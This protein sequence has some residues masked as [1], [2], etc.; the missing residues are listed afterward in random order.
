LLGFAINRSVSIGVCAGTGFVGRQHFMR[1][2]SVFDH[3]RLIAVAP[4]GMPGAGGTIFD[5]RNLE[6][7]L[8]KLA[9]QTDS[10]RP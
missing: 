3:C 4:F 2:K 7:L 6:P 1:D 5:D 8:E 10:V 9:R